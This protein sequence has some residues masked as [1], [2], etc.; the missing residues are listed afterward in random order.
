AN[1]RAVKKFGIAWGLQRNYKS[2]FS[3]DMN[4]GPGYFFAKVTRQNII[5]QFATENTSGFTILGQ[6][7]LGFWLNKRNTN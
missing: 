1:H 2:R 7:N 6:V 4:V 3:L 5:G